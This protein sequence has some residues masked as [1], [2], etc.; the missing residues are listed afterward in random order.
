MP[1]ERPE[2]QSELAESTSA[3][4]SRPLSEKAYFWMSDLISKSKET[5]GPDYWSWQRARTG[6]LYGA[7]TS[8]LLHNLLVPFILH[9]TRDQDFDPGKFALQTVINVSAVTLVA[10]GAYAQRDLAEDMVI[11]GRVITAPLRSFKP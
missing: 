11:F 9:A 8:S 7:L 3:D 10:S 6:A 4:I 1:I 2:P 5:V